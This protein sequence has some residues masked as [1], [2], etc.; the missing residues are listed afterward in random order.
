MSILVVKASRFFLMACCVLTLGCRGSIPFGRTVQI[1]KS[2]DAAEIKIDSPEQR[3][4]TSKSNKEKDTSVDGDTLLSTQ[5]P[6][7]DSQVSDSEKV[8]EVSVA[9]VSGAMINQGELT[10][11]EN[12][13]SGAVAQNADDSGQI[14]LASDE[15][16]DLKEQSV[17]EVDVE[18]VVDE[19][20]PSQKLLDIDQDVAND[21]PA[22]VPVVV[23]VPEFSKEMSAEELLTALNSC[24]PEK[25]KEAVQ[26]FVDLVA[27]QASASH[28]PNQVSDEIAKALK[29][30]LVLPESNIES[31]AKRPERLALDSEQ[32]ESSSEPDKVITF[33]LTDDSA[34][35]ENDSESATVVAEAADLN[36]DRPS[37]LESTQAEEVAVH[38][39]ALDLPAGQDVAQVSLDSQ[40]EGLGNAS[41]EMQ[42]PKMEGVDQSQLLSALI[43]SLQEVPAGETDQDRYGRLIKL[44]HLMVLAGDPEAAMKSM[45]ER[46]PAEQEFL[47]HQLQGLW[48]LID[49]EGHPSPNRRFTSVA[50]E[51]RE[52]AKHAGAATD[53]LEITRLAFCTD[54]EAYGR[55]T[56]FAK[57]E[58]T[59]GEQVILY[60]EVENFS[61]SQSEAG[62]ELN[63]QGSYEIFDSENERVFD[64]LLPA[65]RQLSSNHLRDYFIAY[66]M[67]LP[68]DLP[69]GPYRLKL[70]MEDLV[71]QKYGQHEID[72]TILPK[73]R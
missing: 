11:T 49:P 40:H 6:V 68:D 62:Y 19:Q 12:A 24:P 50:S 3:L 57:P 17:P 53:S 33:T 28:Q 35:P 66:Q 63:V 38:E 26:Q 43:A 9:A 69:S 14:K 25:R 55:V 22:S 5:D 1:T 8:G 18:A 51:F 58:F 48:H 23:A 20:S 29:A 70:T 39:E 37:V 16:E 65:D 52:A 15:S 41:A 56:P 31:N 54:I 67:F 13:L 42:M 30:E 44:G 61:A 45:G 60:C 47:R 34:N 10:A 36:E 2:S 32:A 4:A 64:Q 72:F 7:S 59:A 21:Q 27:D 71:G 73:N 46:T